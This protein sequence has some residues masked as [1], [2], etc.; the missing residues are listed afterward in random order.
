[1]PTLKPILISLKNF[2]FKTGSYVT[3]FVFLSLLLISSFITILNTIGNTDSNPSTSCNTALIKINGTLVEYKSASADTWTDE[4]VAGDIVSY[5]DSIENNSEIKAVILSINSGGG[6][7]IGGQKIANALKRMTK[8]TVSLIERQGLS[9]SYWLA[10][11]ASKIYA[12]N[13]SDVGDIGI[14]QEQYEQVKKDKQDGYTYN[15]LTSDKYKAIGSYHVALT[16]DD[17]NILMRDIM[18]MHNIFVDEVSANRHLDRNV[19]AKLA[20]GSS[21]LGGDALKAGLIDEVGDMYDVKNYL[22][23]QIGEDVNVC[24]Y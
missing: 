8:P 14:I 19:V 9:S 13:L 21:M 5:L 16:E 23:G 15:V 6:S 11:G 10:T 12:S 4:T 20:D 22:S 18:K 17:K 24:E 2:F 3:V 1:M 7:P